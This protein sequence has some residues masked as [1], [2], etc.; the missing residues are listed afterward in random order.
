MKIGTGATFLDGVSH[1]VIIL[2][3]RIQVVCNEKIVG[4]AVSPDSLA[5]RHIRPSLQSI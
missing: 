1:G 2:P 3:R 4:H 5:K